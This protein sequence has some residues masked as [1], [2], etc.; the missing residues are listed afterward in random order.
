MCVCVDGIRCRGVV[1]F[2]VGVGCIWV[3]CWVMRVY[4]E[5]VAWCCVFVCVRAGVVCVCL[6]VRV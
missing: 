5:G 4:L 1:R 6:Y 3:M 2:G